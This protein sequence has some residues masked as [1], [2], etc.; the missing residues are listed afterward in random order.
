MH[1]SPPTPC[2]QAVPWPSR[3][4]A[5]L[6]RHFRQAVL[7]LTVLGGL[8]A[9]PAQ[10]APVLGTAAA[11]AVLG[12]STVT[13]TGATTLVGDL[14]VH[15]GTDITGQGTITLTGTVHDH[16]AVAQMAQADALS[17][18]NTLAGLVPSSVLTG[19]NLGGLTL[20]AG[21]YFFASSAQL[22]GTLVL[23]ALNDPNSMFVF[24]IGSALTTA[25]NA[26][27]QVING[28]AANVYWQV[29]SS[30][31]LGTATLFAGSL[32]AD[33][34]VTL[35]TTAAINCGRAIALHAAVTLDTNTI[36]TTCPL[37]GG[38]TVP[39]PPSWA[40]VGLAL[41]L[42]PLRRRLQPAAR[43]SAA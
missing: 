27:V 2:R 4:A 41:A 17:A 43:A 21:T 11:F 24:Q 9:L 26:V 39:E 30:A 33:Q 28:S 32:I 7:V 36:S 37:A 6:G 34:S 25:S 16:D 14:G 18:F 1:P 8:S 5:W 10:A 31:T 3:P 42:L 20:R 13:N 23:D 29:G 19:Q 35:N 15:P 22:T 40:L 12:A 38:P